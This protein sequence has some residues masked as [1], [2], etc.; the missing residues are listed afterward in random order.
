MAE[1]WPAGLPQT[2]LV[3]GFSRA[4]PSKAI[5]FTPAS[6]KTRTRRRSTGVQRLFTI[7]MILTKAQVATFDTYFSTTLQGGVLSS[8]FTD[9]ADD[10]AIDFLIVGDPTISPVGVSAWRLTFGAERTA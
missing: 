5:V 4:T 10:A 9:P 6:G 8:T 3:E 7:T 1:S 2:P